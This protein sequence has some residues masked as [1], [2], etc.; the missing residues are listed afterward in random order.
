MNSVCLLMI[1]QLSHNKQD[2]WHLASPKVGRRGRARPSLAAPL[3]LLGTFSHELTSAIACTYSRRPLSDVVQ[4]GRAERLAVSTNQMA[5]LQVRGGE[6]GLPLRGAVLGQDAVE[7]SG[8]V[9]QDLFTYDPG[10]VSTAACASELTYIDGEAGILLHRG[11][12]IEDLAAHSTHL[13]VAF[14]LLKGE[15]PTKGQQHDFEEQV[16][17]ARAVPAEMGDICRALPRAAHPMSIL[18]CL[19]ASLSAF[20][21]IELDLEDEKVRQRVASN[22]IGK[23]PTLV[24]MSLRQH[25][26]KEILEPDAALGYAENFLYMVFGEP[27]DGVVAD[28]LERILIL[29]ADHEQNAST[30]TVRLAGSTGTN[31]YAAISAGVGALWGP[32]HGGANEAV[33][34]MLAE[35]GSVENIE[36]F[37]LRAQDRE[38]SFKLM[39]FGHRV[40][41]NYDPRA[42]ILR[43]SCHEVLN[44]LGT[45]D[46]PLLELAQTLEQ[47]A[48]ED[49]YFVG[50]KLFPNVDFYSG[51]ILQAIGIPSSAF[52]NIFAL[53]RTVGWIAQWN[54]MHR[55]PLKIG[56]PRQL[57][58]GP[59]K[60]EFVALAD[61]A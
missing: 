32:S 44:A 22:L 7:V 19:C 58:V 14:L 8:L 49:D 53:A 34:K 50:R 59:G 46:S 29:H 30:S 9:R 23:I 37:L 21:H 40:Y 5:K 18:N 26:G 60:R 12:S 31:P 39:G 4:V 56:R 28:A 3:M 57:Y 11:Y 41:K 10:F 20:E 48:L 13:E 47:H 42:A 45:Q 2:V 27:P 36:T 1:D 52:T 35:I 38:D 25:M 61:R 33:L 24:A 43:S 51:I 55:E 6:I 17:E 16:L 15:L 54:E